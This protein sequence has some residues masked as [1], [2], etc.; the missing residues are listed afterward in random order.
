VEKISAWEA[1]AGAPR[2]GC[3][4]ERKGGGTGEENEGNL[5]AC[6]KKAASNVNVIFYLAHLKDKNKSDLFGIMCVSS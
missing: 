4:R 1:Q 3:S 2:V 6:E 5:G